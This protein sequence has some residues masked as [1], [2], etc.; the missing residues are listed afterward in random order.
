MFYFLRWL[1]DYLTIIYWIRQWFSNSAPQKSRCPLPFPRESTYCFHINLSNAHYWSCHSLLKKLKNRCKQN[2]FPRF[3]QDAG[4]VRCGNHLPPHK[5]TRNISTCGTI[6]TDPY[7]MLAED[8]RLPKR[9]TYFFPFSLFV[10]VYVYAL[11]CDFVCRALLSP[12]V[13]GFWLSAFLCVC[14]CVFNSF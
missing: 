5:Y 2:L 14:V 4:G 8:L 10:S 11:F 13:L 7:W 12:F 3:P 1:A 9:Y 6:P